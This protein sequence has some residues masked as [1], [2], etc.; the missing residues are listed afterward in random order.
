MGASSDST[1]SH[2]YANFFC[3]V[4]DAGHVWSEWH[5]GN[6]TCYHIRFRCLGFVIRLESQMP[7]ADYALCRH[8]HRE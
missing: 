2:I 7:G 6:V 4:F 3:A 5:E 8:G 1:D